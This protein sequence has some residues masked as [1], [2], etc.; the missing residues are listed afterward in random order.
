MTA[1]NPKPD[2]IAPLADAITASA[3]SDPP[4]PTWPIAMVVFTMAYAAYVLVSLILGISLKLKVLIVLITG[5]VPTGVANP[6]LWR[7]ESTLSLLY[8]LLVLAVIAP[9]IGLWRRRRWALWVLGSWA[10]ANLLFMLGQVVIVIGMS[11]FSSS[12]MNWLLWRG[13]SFLWSTW[14]PAFVIIWISRPTIRRQFG[15]WVN[16][17]LPIPRP[18]WA[19]VIG[20]LSIFHAVLGM[21]DIASRVAHAA[22]QVVVPVG[23]SLYNS[24][25]VGASLADWLQW[26][27]RVVNDL[28]P[29]LALA[30]L[31]VPAIALLK[32]RPNA[33]RL[34][35]IGAAIVLVSVLA[36]PIVDVWQGFQFGHYWGPSVRSIIRDLI[37]TIYPLFLLIWFLRPEVKRKVAQWREPDTPDIMQAANERG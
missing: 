35:V 11:M 26:I 29:C 37:P 1:A 3:A 15:Q 25:P 30:A 8:P 27:W 17:T 13:P 2:A 19:V 4:G 6:S 9:A 23:G 24:L 28:L 22:V 18:T 32:R 7:L 10:V 31:A 21:I 20:W 33:A 12:I 14:L 5:F 16:G 34:H 36:E